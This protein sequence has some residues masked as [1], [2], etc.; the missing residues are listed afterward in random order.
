MATSSSSRSR[1]S[2]PSS[3]RCRPSSTSWPRSSAS[4]AAA[5]FVS[6]RPVL[7]LGPAFE[8]VL[9][10]RR[11]KTAVAARAD[12]HRAEVAGLLPAPDRRDVDPEQTRNL[13]DAE[14][15]LGAGRQLATPQ[16]NYAHL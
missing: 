6:P 3:A 9:D 11:V 8:R 1:M 16:Q 13:A 7:A 10:I 2:S 14:K 15:W 12:P 4:P 5:G